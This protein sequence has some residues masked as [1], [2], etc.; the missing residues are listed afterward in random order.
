MFDHH[1]L[2]EFTV[3]NL[4]REPMRGKGAFT[5]AIAPRNPPVSIRGTNRASE[6]PAPIARSFHYPSPERVS[7]AL[8]RAQTWVDA[9]PRLHISGLRDYALESR[10]W[11]IDVRLAHNLVRCFARAGLR[12]GTRAR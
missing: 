9:S 12:G 7:S 5:P 10:K 1:A 11:N 3:S 6:N 8:C 4:E 2:C